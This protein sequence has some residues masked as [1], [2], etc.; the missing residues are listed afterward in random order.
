[1]TNIIKLQAFIKHLYYQYSTISIQDFI[2]YSYYQQTNIT[3][4]IS[5]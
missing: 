4:T 3:N 1:M 5:I 2:K